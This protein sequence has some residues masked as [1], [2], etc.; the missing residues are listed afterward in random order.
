M[1]L[2]FLSPNFPPNFYNFCLRLKAAGET[3]CGIG[4]QDFSAL[5]PDLQNS[6]AW[7]CRVDSLHNYTQVRGAFGYLAE[8]FGPVTKVESL[9][10]AWLETE[11]RLRTDFGLP[12]IGI[13]GV[14]HIRRKSLMKEVFQKQGLPFARWEK[15]TSIEAALA[16]AEKVGFPVIVK[17][18]AGVGA[19]DT[20]KF[21]TAH[22]IRDF[23]GFRSQREYIIEEYLTGGIVTFDG[24]AGK[25]GRIVF[26][27][28]HVYGQTPMDALN[29]QRDVFYY[30]LREIPHDLAEAGR[31]IIDGFGLSEKFFHFEFFRKADGGLSVMEI[32]VRPPGGMTVDMFN[33]SC[34]FDI[35]AIWA[36]LMAG[37]DL[38]VAYERK[39]FT[40]FVSRRNFRHYLYSHDEV[41]ERF[42]PLIAAHSP[43]PAGFASAMGDYGY[44]I[45]APLLDDVIT[46]EQSIHRTL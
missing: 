40:A 29:D 34:D 30:S 16:F 20:H 2:I 25:G 9:N 35:Y 31:K 7:Y 21:K 46:A 10:E 41:L 32:N 33:Y 18:D 23:H 22:E 43:F 8:K 17:P 45:R 39:Y 11:A 27:A 1:S 15:L 44:L 12:G 28:S 42:G 24:L 26:C 19:D 13:D 3:V 37:R 38:H 4:D 14:G 5:R 36:E 6:L